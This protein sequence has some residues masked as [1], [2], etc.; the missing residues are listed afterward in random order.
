MQAQHPSSEKMNKP[1]DTN[2]VHK[3]RTDVP[4]RTRKKYIIKKWIEESY[5]FLLCFVLF[6]PGKCSHEPEGHASGFLQCLVMV[7]VKDPL[8]G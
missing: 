4:A 3:F 7:Q 2:A 8:L 1:R 5:S 6:F